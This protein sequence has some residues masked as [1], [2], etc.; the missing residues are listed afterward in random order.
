MV[1]KGLV[2][3]TGSTRIWMYWN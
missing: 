1:M 3:S 2:V